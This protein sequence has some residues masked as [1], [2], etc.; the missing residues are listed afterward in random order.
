MYQTILHLGNER[1][2][3]GVDTIFRPH[4]DM[5]VGVSTAVYSYD[6]FLVELHQLGSGPCEHDDP[7]HILLA[8]H[9]LGCMEELKDIRVIQGRADIRI[10]FPH[11]GHLV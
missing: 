2:V 5:E 6:H 9:I 10:Q 3:S 1:F 8:E 11:D 4:H 7:L